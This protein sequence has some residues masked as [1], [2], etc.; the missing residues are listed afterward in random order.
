MADDQR[1]LRRCVVDLGK[2]L[3]QR[4]HLADPLELPGLHDGQRLVEPHG[5]AAAQLVGLDGRRTRHPHLPTGGEHVDRAVLVSVEEHA[6]AAGRL[7][8]PVDLLA[9]GE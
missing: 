3:A 8:E 7:G 5:L 9:Q 4:R 6:I 1:P 2:Q